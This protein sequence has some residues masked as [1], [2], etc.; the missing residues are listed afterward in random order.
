MNQYIAYR[1]LHIRHLSPFDT[2]GIRGYGWNKPY[3]KELSKMFSITRSF[4]S[5]ML[6]S[7]NRYLYDD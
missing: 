4:S 6:D 7:F 2:N 5:A 3:I 1:L